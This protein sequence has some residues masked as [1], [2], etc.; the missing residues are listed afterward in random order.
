MACNLHFPTSCYIFPAPASRCQV[1]PPCR[2]GTRG[3]GDTH[4]HINLGTNPDTGQRYS[5]CHW[6]PLPAEQT[7]SAGCSR[8][9]CCGAAVYHEQDSDT[10]CL[11]AHWHCRHRTVTTVQHNLDIRL[12]DISIHIYI[13]R[14]SQLHL[15]SSQSSWCQTDT[16]TLAKLIFSQSTVD[17][18][19]W[20]GEKDRFLKLKKSFVV[21]RSRDHALLTWYLFRTFSQSAAPSFPLLWPLHWSPAGHGQS[22][23]PP[24]R[25]RTTATS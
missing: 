16:A 13:S 12:L 9:L 2:P 25:Q 18:S 3:P 20:S 6:I 7:N 10:D 24:R 22:V 17:Q 4:C 15:I 19:S 8:Q 14:L 5:N 1:V 11:S 21:L 23:L